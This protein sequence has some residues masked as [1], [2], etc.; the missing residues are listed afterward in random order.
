MG[1]EG[2]L[3]CLLV[4]KTSVSSEAARVGSIPTYSRHFIF[5]WG[6]ATWRGH[7]VTFDF[8]GSPAM[9]QDLLRQIP[10][11]DLLLLQESLTALEGEFSR[12]QILEATRDYLSDLRKGILSGQV[13]QVGTTEELA[14]DIA[15]R[16]ARHGAYSLCP[17]VNATGVVLH[18][19]LGRAPL[20]V[21]VASHVAEVAQG[22]SNLEY[23]LAEGRRGSR[24]A[25]VEDLLCQLTGVEAALVVNNNAAAVFLM[26]NTFCRDRGV[27]I[28]RGELVEIGG[29]FRIPDIMAQSGALLV[30][31]GTTNKTHL[32]D[33]ARVMETG[34]ASA[35]LKVHRSNFVMRG[36]TE[37]VSVDELTELARPADALV[38][39]DAGALPLVQ[40][41]LAG[42]GEEPTLRR[43]LDA[44]A[45]VV[46]FSADKLLGSA[47]AGIL[48]GRRELIDRM[49]HNQLTRMLR[50][51]KISLAALEATLDLYRSPRLAREQVPVVR[52]LTMG[53]EECR[54]RAEQLRGLLVEMVPEVEC[55]LVPVEDEVGGGALPDV[56]LS[57]WALAVSVEGLSAD[58]LAERMRGCSWP[59]IVRIKEGRVLLS[60]RTLCEGDEERVCLALE[61]LVSELFKDVQ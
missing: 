7:P 50:I 32:S 38:L 44:G 27:A 35:L 49:R 56:G 21:A 19:N 42:M 60:V 3:V 34:E 48:L 6:P 57:G 10:K 29:S 40:L 43:V 41:D 23:D 46:C 24:Y 47:Q 36:F 12:E 13:G 2:R 15:G 51:D 4:L 45:D 20:G 33:Y 61:Q 5:K 16:L 28:S 26:L 37:S 18:T 17:V 52:M 22:Y 31:V 11:V 54:A 39:Y 30:E 55:Q 58:E 9:N 1:V 14:R 59:V 53:A 8:V 25:H